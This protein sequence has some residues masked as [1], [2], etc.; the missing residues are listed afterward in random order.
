MNSLCGRMR[1]ERGE[2]MAQH[3]AGRH[4]LMVV[5][6][7]VLRGEARL[8]SAVV[9]YQHDPLTLGDC[10]TQVPG[11]SELHGFCLLFFPL[12]FPCVNQTFTTHDIRC[13]HYMCN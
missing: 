2:G 6:G 3:E 7:R 1:D 5:G 10:F 13:D 4:Q 8:L 11:T 9:P 12:F